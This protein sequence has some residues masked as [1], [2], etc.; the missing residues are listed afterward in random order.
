[1]H[2]TKW[3]KHDGY[4]ESICSLQEGLGPILKCRAVRNSTGDW[5]AIVRDF[6]TGKMVAS[7]PG[8]MSFSLALDQAQLMALKF[9]KSEVD[10]GFTLGGYYE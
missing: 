9:I 10:T 6:G 3:R 4:G 5:E 7:R 8:P 1:M 2:F